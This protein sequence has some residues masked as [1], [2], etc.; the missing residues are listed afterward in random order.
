M[1]ALVVRYVKVCQL[2]SSPP[3][4]HSDG[5]DECRPRLVPSLSRYQARF[6][7]PPL[8]TDSNADDERKYTYQRQSHLA[9][10]ISQ[11][12]RLLKWLECEVDRSIGIFVPGRKVLAL[13]RTSLSLSFFAYVS[14]FLPE[15]EL[16][17]SRPLSIPT[18][19]FRNTSH[20]LGR[21]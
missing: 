4:Q 9:N 7:I 15:L 21:I 2:F 8:F 20:C 13:F 1:S 19:H 11:D 17:P 18:H 3:L 5:M 12:K 6:C 10:D 16:R 14:F